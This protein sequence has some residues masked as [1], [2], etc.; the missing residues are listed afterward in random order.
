MSTPTRNATAADYLKGMTDA[1]ESVEATGRDATVLTVERAIAVA[2]EF[3]HAV[4]REGTKVL[5]VG[6]GGSAGIVSHVHNDLCKCV[7][8]RALVFNEV[9]LLTA[10]ANDDGYDTV[11]ETPMRLWAEEGDVL[12]AVSS[13]GES[14]NIVRAVTLAAARQCRIV[15]LS[16]FK[17]GNR[18]RALGDINLYV[19]SAVYGYVEMAHAILAHC[20]TDMAGGVDFSRPA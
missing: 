12:I 1:L 2:V 19:P 18:L 16:G 7:G 11:F 3:L 17:S 8:V 6:N 15:T 20:I 5:L 14:S 10:L 4:K 13:G 9:P